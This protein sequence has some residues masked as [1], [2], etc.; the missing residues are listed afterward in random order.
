MFV[1]DLK[2]AEQE[3][4]NLHIT[5]HGPAKRCHFAANTRSNLSHP[6]LANE[7]SY[8]ELAANTPRGR[9]EV[10]TGRLVRREAIAWPWW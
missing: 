5:W 8:I 1:H 10:K 4:K 6:R 3:T 2:W 9:P 7:A